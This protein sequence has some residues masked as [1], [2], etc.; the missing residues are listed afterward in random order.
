MTTYETYNHSPCN[1]FEI[2]AL[3]SELKEQWNW[4]SGK[5]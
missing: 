5:K 2:V 4:K 3:S 1:R